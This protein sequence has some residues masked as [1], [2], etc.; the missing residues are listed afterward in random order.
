MQHNWF[1][2]SDH[3]NFQINITLLLKGVLSTPYTAKR[4]L[5]CFS[6]VPKT[7]GT[8][9]ESIL[10][11]NFLLSETLHINAPDLNKHPE[12]I[13]LKKNHPKLICGHHPMHGLLYQLL[14]EQPLFHV[15]QL[16]HPVDRVLSYYNYV[17]GKPDHPMNEHAQGKSITAFL[18][19]KHSPELSNGQ[20]KRFSGYLHSKA[21][22]EDIVL[23]TLAQQT[24]SQCFSMVLTTCLFDEG[25]LLLKKSLGL[26]D[27]FYL[28]SNVSKRFISKD[29]LSSAELQTIESMNQADIKLFEWAKNNCLALIEQELTAEDISSFK[30]NNQKWAELISNQTK[31]REL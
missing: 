4:H 2:S 14:P 29:Q 17:L 22:V 24:L 12:A 8:S 19:T 5:L 31:S 13:K 1:N 27:I 6:H 28:K 20:A 25:L 26:R 3:N 18:Q 23:F 15:T 30:T 16:R 10:A 11:K 7:G 21:V 9:L